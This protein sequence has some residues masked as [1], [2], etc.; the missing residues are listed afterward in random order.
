MEVGC[1]LGRH[2]HLNQTRHLL[3]HMAAAAQC[4]ELPELL[5][6]FGVCP[7]RSADCTARATSA[8]CRNCKRWPHEFI[9]VKWRRGSEAFVFAEGGV[10]KRFRSRLRRRGVDVACESCC[11]TANMM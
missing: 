8:A 9:F 7:W 5:A 4:L 3:G 11:L 6:G 10:R 1:R 2:H